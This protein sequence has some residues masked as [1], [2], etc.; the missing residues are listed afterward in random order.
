M[1][2]EL[3]PSVVNPELWYPDRSDRTT[4]N[5]VRRAVLEQWDYTCRFCGHRALKHMQIHH[6][7]LHRKRRP[8]LVPV[9][10]A[11]HAVLHI[12]LSLMFGAVEVWKSRISQRE[13]I[14]RTRQGIREGKSLRQIKK[15]LPISR[16]LLSPKS[17][18][19][20]NQLEAK[21]GRRPIISLERPHCAVFVKLKKWQLEESWEYLLHQPNK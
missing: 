16:G 2:L 20:A 15:T 12:G 9:C 5:K 13:I 17:V 8:I 10:L 14:L 21:I 1:R 4:W 18:E 6:L 19:W 7:Y 11:C 3:R